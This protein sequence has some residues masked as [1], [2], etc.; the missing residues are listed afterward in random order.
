K[1]KNRK[2]SNEEI[3]IFE[4]VP[5]E[6][7][8]T[9]VKFAT[10]IAHKSLDYAHVFS[11]FTDLTGINVDIVAIPQTEYIVK[12]T[13]MKASGTAPDIVV[14]NFEFP[15]TL[16]LMQPLLESTT[17]INVKDSVWDQEVAKLYTINGKCYA[18][19]GSNSNWE[20]ASP[21][22]YYNIPLLKKYGIKTPADYVNDNN[23]NLDT[24]VKCAQDCKDAGIFTPCEI[25][26]T[27]FS[28][29][30]ADGPYHYDASKN[31]YSNTMGT[32]KFRN[33]WSW[34]ATNREKGLFK[35]SNSW[36]SSLTSGQTGFVLTGAYGLR[37]QPGWFYQMDP[38]DIG[39]AYLPKAE[40]SD[41]KYPTSTFCRGYGI[42]DGAKNP[43][44]AGYFLR[45][46]L[47]DDWYNDDEI[48]KD[49][50][51]A[52]MHKDLLKIKNFSHPQLDGIV[53]VQYADYAAFFNDLTMSTPQQVTA[54][55]DK[56]SRQMDYCV[57]KANSLIANAK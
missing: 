30:Y 50:R 31:E 42:A 32:E 16:P 13:G 24:M 52:Q 57:K 14:D 38:S 10:W 56:V 49:S 43:K 47:N 6:L 33:T 44:G 26:I 51:A 21:L 22:T 8:G 34:L 53:K 28:N 20:M 36:A 48:F 25:D 29:V 1:A 27:V 45:Y 19:T 7:K 9:T 3:A 2:S 15:R 12:L 17:G 37:K 5:S 46:F 4:N 35:L 40:K 11:D 41:S 18:I 55:I 39:Y 54:N 23:W